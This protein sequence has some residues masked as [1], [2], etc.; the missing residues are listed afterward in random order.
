MGKD[1]FT[2]GA[3]VRELPRILANESAVMTLAK[4]GF[5]AAWEIVKSDN[6]ELDSALFRAVSNATKA[7]EN[8]ALSEINELKKGNKKKVQR[9]RALRAALDEVMRQANIKI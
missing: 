2:K 5:G 3:E 1:R 6:P 8:A 7:L 9:I 4:K